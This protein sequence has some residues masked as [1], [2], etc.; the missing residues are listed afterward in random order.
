MQPESVLAYILSIIES[1]LG[2]SIGPEQPL[3]EV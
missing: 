2:A 1:V 3:M